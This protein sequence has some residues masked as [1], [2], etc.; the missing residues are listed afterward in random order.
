MTLFRWDGKAHIPPEIWE[1]VKPIRAAVYGTIEDLVPVTTDFVF[2]NV[3]QDDEDGATEYSTL[4]AL[5]GRRG[6][7]FLPVM[8]HCE[9]EEQV[10]RIDTPD[11]YF[12]DAMRGGSL[13]QGTFQQL[14]RAKLPW[15]FSLLHLASHVF[16]LMRGTTGVQ[17]R[18]WN[19]GYSRS[20]NYGG[21]ACPLVLI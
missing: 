2:T 10:R 17:P 11:R 7:L 20:R 1:R 14:D 6:S 19:L 12:D 13:R 21:R 18:S 9:E 8:L 16:P 4:R 3:L 5:A 15:F